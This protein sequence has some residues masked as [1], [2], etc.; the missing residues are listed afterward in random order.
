[1]KK[2]LE[3]H[4]LSEYLPRITV[5]F[6]AVTVLL[7]LRRSKRTTIITGSFNRDSF[8]GNTASAG[9]AQ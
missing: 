5:F 2:F 9:N 1:M 8:N 3:E 4:G 7:L 6:M